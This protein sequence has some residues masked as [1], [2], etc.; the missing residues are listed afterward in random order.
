MDITIWILIGICLSLYR[1]LRL[2]A[3]LGKLKI[4]QQLGTTK[5]PE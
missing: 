4:G 5:N 3:L 1:I 2:V